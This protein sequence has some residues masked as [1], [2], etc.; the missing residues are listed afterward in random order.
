MRPITASRALTSLSLVS[1]MVAGIVGVSSRAQRA[2]A[3]PVTA[4]VGCPSHAVSVQVFPCLPPTC[5]PHAAAPSAVAAPVLARRTPQGLTVRLRPIPITPSLT[6][7]SLWRDV[8]AWAT[9]SWAPARVHVRQPSRIYLASLTSF[10]PEV[11]AQSCTGFGDLR[12][13]AGRL[14]WTEP[15]SLALD[16]P[17]TSRIW[18]LDLQTGRRSLVNADAFPVRNNYDSSS[19]SVDGNTL[20]WTRGTGT[21]RRTNE[22]VRA[23]IVDRRLPDGPITTLVGPIVVNLDNSGPPHEQTISGPQRAGSILLWERSR[24]N[25]QAPVGDLLMKNLTT[26]RGRVLVRDVV[27][28]AVTNGRKVFWT[29]PVG[30]PGQPLVRYDL[31]TGTHALLSTVSNGFE[32]LLPSPTITGSVLTWRTVALVPGR[33]AYGLI[34]R[35][36]RTG[37]QYQLATG[38]DVGISGTAF[39][40]PGW[41]WANQV[42][43]GEQTISS[44]GELQSSYLAITT[45]P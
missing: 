37:Q 10:R 21:S 44:A 32:S 3:A 16:R 36:L 23:A 29:V 26:G 9:P 38:G 13:A 1:A 22:P 20:T 30:R 28:R 18:A 43:W 33:G 12:L 42:G 14:L 31:R 39:S 2:R 27:S 15:V 41:G 11:I 25:G 4:L 7:L 5:D 34:A 17:A 24:W 40:G 45:I 35:D 6:G 19:F 8:A